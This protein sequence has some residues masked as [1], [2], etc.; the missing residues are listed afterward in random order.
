MGSPGTEAEGAVFENSAPEFSDINN[1][2]TMLI[3]G[4]QEEAAVA[5]RSYLEIL[6]VIPAIAILLALFLAVRID[7]YLNPSQKKIL[8]LIIVLVF[9]LIIQNYMDYYLSLQAELS[10]FRVTT[11]IVG[12]AVRPVIIVLFLLIVKPGGRYLPAWILAG[13]NAAVYMTAYFSPIAFWFFNNSFLPGPLNDT[14]TVVS[15]VLLIWLLILTIRE[16]KPRQR[17]ESWIPVL[18]IVFIVGSILLDRYVIFD[19]QPVSFLTIGISISCVFFYIWLHLQFVREHEQALLAEQRIRIMMTQIQPHFLF[20]TLSIIRS[21]CAK[22]P[23]TAIGTIEKFSRYLRQNLESLNQT[24]LIPL[25]K[26]LEHTR[27]YTDIEQQRFPN[28]HVN[29]VVEDEDF[30]L[31]ALTIQPL[32]ENAIRHGVRGRDDGI[33]DI[34]VR[35]E[36]NAHVIIIADNGVGFDVNKPGDDKEQHIG[37]ENVKA[38][39]G[40]MC[41]GTMTVESCVGEGTTV[42]LRIPVGEGSM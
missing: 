3:P 8:Y 21:L 36:E 32:V 37:M 11:S 14:C 41:G 27:I 42:T 16:F 23:S 25:K 40:Q 38:R 7:S 35:R 30:R 26:E 9:S 18:A 5:V 4:K 33:V 13:A 1:E 6:S 31:P 19:D 28:T 17:K 10:P 2:G 20:N 22:D 29:Y 34:T 24:K 12:Y 39:I 15:A